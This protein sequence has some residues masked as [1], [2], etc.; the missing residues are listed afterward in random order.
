MENV[1]KL[2][3]ETD[4][5]FAKRV[6]GVMRKPATESRSS[7]QST[8]DDNFADVMEEHFPSG[9]SIRARYGDRQPIRETAGPSP[10][11]HQEDDDDALA[12]AM[13]RAFPLATSYLDD[14]EEP[15]SVQGVSGAKAPDAG[16][17]QL[18]LSKV[19]K[20]RADLSDPDD[21][22][23]VKGLVDGKWV[24]LPDSVPESWKTVGATPRNVA[25]LGA[26]P[27]VATSTAEPTSLDDLDDSK[28]AEAMDDIYG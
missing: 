14:E 17:A 21:P 15:A 4:T 16:L 22:G 19:E 11:S 10:V 9:C 27:R 25:D 20:V 24:R 3:G 12:R 1:S 6:V 13:N 18:D 8:D 28:L 5:Q 23:H 26:K 7:A 2:E